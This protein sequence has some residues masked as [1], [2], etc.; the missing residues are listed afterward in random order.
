MLCTNC[1]ELRYCLLRCIVLP[2]LQKL[3]WQTGC[4]S[5]PACSS[6]MLYVVLLSANAPY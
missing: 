2:V 6:M 1:A 5:Q 4:V 3:Y